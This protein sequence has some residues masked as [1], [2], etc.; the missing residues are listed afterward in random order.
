[1]LAKVNAALMPCAKNGKTLENKTFAKNLIP[2]TPIGW[3]KSHAW[4]HN[5][6]PGGSAKLASARQTTCQGGTNG[7]WGGCVQYSSAQG[8]YLGGRFCSFLINHLVPL[9]MIN[10]V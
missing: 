10:V 4:F 7:G 9:P 8:N 2:E 5:K 3:A 6:G 1:M